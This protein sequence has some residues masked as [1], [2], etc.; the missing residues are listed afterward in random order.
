MLIVDA[1]V[2]IKWF[3][4]EHDSPLARAVLL[5]D[6]LAAPELLVAELCN[7][8]WKA[9]RR[10]LM[11]V[12]QMDA[13][14]GTIRRY[15]GLLQPMDPLAPRALAI[16][17]ALDHPAYDCFYLALA[18]RDLAPLVTADRQFLT[19]IQGT[20]WATHVRDLAT[21]GPTP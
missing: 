16:A 14:A 11:T 3:K 2:A 21:F 9:F 8:C 4:E 18:E 17:R 7:I 12:E 13:T 1:S 6:T 10:A 20:P 19:R 5:A 15:V